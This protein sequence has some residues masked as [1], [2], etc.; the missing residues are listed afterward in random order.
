MSNE[1]QL[2]ITRPAMDGERMAKIAR[3]HGMVPWQ[4]PILDILWIMPDKEGLR[5]IMN[6]N[7]ILVTSRHALTSLDKSG[8][9]LP[10]HAI[11]VAIGKA[12]AQALTDRGIVAHI[13]KQTDSEGLLNEL[14]LHLSDGQHIALLKGVGGRKLISNDLQKK[15]FIVTE[16]ALYRRICKKIDS[17]MLDT[18]LKQPYS[19]LSVASSETLTCTLKATTPTQARKLIKLPLAVI[20]ERVAIFARSKGWKGQI[21]V[22]PEVSSLGLIQAA[23]LVQF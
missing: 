15:G 8:I 6:A 14:A 20:S 3:E 17:G 12:T 4:M 11:Y 23:R 7:M 22:A 19:V 18:F 16:L 9:S 5:A 10:P 2:W 1:L 21:V 13:P